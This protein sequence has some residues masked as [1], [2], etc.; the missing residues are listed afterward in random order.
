MQSREAKAAQ[1]CSKQEI[2]RGGK[3]PQACTCL[4]ERLQGD[5]G[6]SPSAP[7][8]ACTFVY[9]SWDHCMCSLLAELWLPR[10]SLLLGFWLQLGTVQIQENHSKQPQQSCLTRRGLPNNGAEDIQEYFRTIS[11]KRGLNLRDVFGQWLMVP[12]AQLEQDCTYNYSY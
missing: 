4:Q 6:N 5:A 10:D 8:A 7:C 3:A 11:F 9:W 12:S 1:L 2:S